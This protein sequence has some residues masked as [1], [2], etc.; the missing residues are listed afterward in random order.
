MRRASRLSRVVFWVG[1]FLWLVLPLAALVVLGT[2]D[3]DTEAPRRATWATVGRTTRDRTE[4]VT[5][6]PTLG[7]LVSLFA[8]AALTGTV[9]QV[10]L[11]PGKAVA[12]GDRVLLVDNVWR[13]AT[14]EGPF[15][16]VLRIDDVGP[17]VGALNRLLVK[18]GLVA[19]DADRF[20]LRTARGV[21]ALAAI[22][23]AGRVAELDPAWL[24]HL[25]AEGAV[26]AEVL[27]QVGGPV[28]A[29][30][31][32]A[33]LVRS[34]ES[35]TITPGE[36][37]QEAAALPG[38]LPAGA[39]LRVNGVELG[40]L[41]PDLAAATAIT[42]PA[43]LAGLAAL[44]EADTETL[45]GVVVTPAPE[46]ARQVPAAAVY[47][48]ARGATCAIWRTGPDGPRRRAAVTVV[49]TTSGVAQVEGLP[50]TAAQVQ[51]G[52]PARSRL[53]C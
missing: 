20:T 16:R 7:P 53:P 41:P 13:L 17:D 10:D 3:E 29:S 1:T 45:A 12:T 36:E 8:S 33:E 47:A 40:T 52:P 5:I 42:E 22:L 32:V 39:V 26:A 51:L 28:S 50:D 30:E 14:A 15:P 23:G 27:V 44:V 37:G 21:E 11:R 18:L 19:G 35:V 34:L 43:L 4:P 9:Q 38:S 25:P 24:I 31:P 6:R 2:S 49:D 46:G 48:D